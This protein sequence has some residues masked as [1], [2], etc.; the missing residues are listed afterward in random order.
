MKRIV[1]IV[2][3]ET[4]EG[5]IEGIEEAFEEIKGRDDNMLFDSTAGGQIEYQIWDKAL[6]QCMATLLDMEYIK[7]EELALKDV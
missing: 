3:A 2:H 1:L 7:E 6:P 5:L 4:K